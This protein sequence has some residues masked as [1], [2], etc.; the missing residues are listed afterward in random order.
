MQFGREAWYYTIYGG[1]GYFGGE[2][3]PSPPAPSPHPSRLNP[4][5]RGGER[6]GGG[7]GG[8][9]GNILGVNLAEEQERDMEKE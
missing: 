6:E 7:G 2:A 1:I 5:R 9:E 3:S 8:K 4:G